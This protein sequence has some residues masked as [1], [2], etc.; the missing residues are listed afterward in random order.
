MLTYEMMKYL[1]HVNCLSQTQAANIKLVS[2][3]LNSKPMPTTERLAS[4]NATMTQNYSG[5]DDT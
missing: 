3:K 5:S 4:N 1:K 2:F